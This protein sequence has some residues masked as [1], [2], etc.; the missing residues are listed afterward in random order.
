M[1][2]VIEV[3]A[4]SV[5]TKE[6]LLREIPKIQ[7]TCGSS[8]VPPIIMENT[9]AFFI[10]GKWDYEALRQTLRNRA[11]MDNWVFYNSIGSILLLK[12]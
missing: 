10:M 7:T 1:V 5:R 3:Q 2:E 11:T 6:T 8:F 12:N 9:A 4:K